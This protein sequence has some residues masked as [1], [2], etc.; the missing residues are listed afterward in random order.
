MDNNENNYGPA[1]A[2]AIIVVIL[3]FGGWYL[4]IGQGLNGPEGEPPVVPE[5]NTEA[6]PIVYGT[7]TAST[8][9]PQAENLENVEGAS[10]SS[11]SEIN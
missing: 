5:I 4:F 9:S 2:V 10:A 3:F 8:S 11:T 7:S 1:I 6:N